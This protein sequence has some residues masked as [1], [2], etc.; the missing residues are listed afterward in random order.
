MNEQ[1]PTLRRLATVVALIEKA[2][3]EVKNVDIETEAK[4]DDGGGFAS[5]MSAMTGATSVPVFDLRIR[6]DDIPENDV[7]DFPTLERGDI[8]DARV[9]DLLGV[10]GAVVDQAFESYDDLVSNARENPTEVV[11][12]DAINTLCGYVARRAGGS[13]V[14]IDAIEVTVAERIDAGIETVEDPADEFHGTALPSGGDK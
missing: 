3:A 11:H 2:G 10:E 4:Y 7:E 13:E 14:D 6:A 5:L 12:D 9:E 8:E 1:A